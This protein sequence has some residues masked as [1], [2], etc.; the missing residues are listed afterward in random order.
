MLASVL[1]STRRRA[2][3]RVWKARKGPGLTDEESAHAFERF[4]RGRRDRLGSGLGL[5]IVKAT[6]ERHAGRATV[7]GSEFAIE[8]P[9]LRELSNNA[10]KPGGEPEKGQ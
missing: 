6:A 1:N 2:L 7:D 4:W 10:G 3:I 9:A 8:V 5:A